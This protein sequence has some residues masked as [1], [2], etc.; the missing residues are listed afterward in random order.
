MDL[1]SAQK[2]S[3]SSKQLP[4]LVVVQAGDLQPYQS[5]GWVV[6]ILRFSPPPL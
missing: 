2:V 4:P 1:Q 6:S 3:A 5:H